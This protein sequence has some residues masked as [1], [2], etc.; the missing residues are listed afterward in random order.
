MV[1]RRAARGRRAGG[2]GDAAAAREEKRGFIF[3]IRRERPLALVQQ[4][5]R[6]VIEGALAA[7]APVAF[8]P[9]AVVVIA[10]GIDV[11]TLT[12]G[13]LK[14]PLFPPQGMDI[15]VTPRRRAPA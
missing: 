4:G 7:V 1:S 9:G 13:T 14:R 3:P 6:E 10:P 8:A 11:L 5:V 15:G 2:W 12:P